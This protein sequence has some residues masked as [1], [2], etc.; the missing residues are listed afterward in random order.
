MAVSRRPQSPLP[1]PT[2]AALDSVRLM[3]GSS[4]Q[5]HLNLRPLAIAVNEWEVRRAADQAMAKIDVRYWVR[6][7][8]WQH[9]VD[10]G[11]TGMRPVP[12]V[13]RAFASP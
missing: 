10:S 8:F 1:S 6:D 2:T 11:L 9:P 7:G 4:P 3:A 5:P 13:R 12:V